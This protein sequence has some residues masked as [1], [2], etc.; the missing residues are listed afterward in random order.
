MVDGLFPVLDRCLPDLPAQARV[1]GGE[2]LLEGL[3]QHSVLARELMPDG[4]SFTDMVSRMFEDFD[5]E[6]PRR[7]R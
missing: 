2:L 1:F 5:G 6:R 3:H 7:G 4:V